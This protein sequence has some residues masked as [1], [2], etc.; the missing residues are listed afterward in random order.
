MNESDC[1]LNSEQDLNSEGRQKLARID[2]VM[3]QF[4]REF[5]GARED[6]DAV[7]AALVRYVEERFSIR[8]DPVGED[9][10]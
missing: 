5:D 3:K 4:S 7:H 10:S 8:P 6:I 9:A 1:N 2:A